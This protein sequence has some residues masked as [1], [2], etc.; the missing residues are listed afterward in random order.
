ML[1]ALMLWNEPNNLSHWNFHLDPGWRVYAAM[2]RQAAQAVRHQAPALTIVA[3][4]ISPID[5]DFVRLLTGE[6]ALESV[7]VLGIHGFPLDWN[8]WRMNEWP[9]K[10]LE[11]AAET[12]KV[13]W[14]TEVGASSFGADE[15]Q[16]FG[17]EA[18]ARLLLDTGGQPERV[19]WYS[20]LDLPP[21]WAA[22]T[23]HRESEGSAYYRHYH[24][25][26]LD[27]QGRPKPAVERFPAGMGVCQW[28][29]FQD[30]RLDL[31]TDWLRRLGVRRL[32][33][34]MSWADWFRP[35]AAAWFDRQMAALAEFDVT[36]TLC[37]TPAHLGIEPHYASPPRDGQEF[38]A[39]AHWV[40]ERYA[41]AA[42][43]AKAAGGGRQ[44]L[45]TPCRLAPAA[46]IG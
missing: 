20:L 6:G 32:R 37:Y 31:A 21:S 4:G 2:V 27:A 38:A 14:A 13:I 1:E 19:Y 46:G 36:L 3:G 23:R 40:A 35:G 12:D 22:T 44:G 30:H 26:L 9:R 25:G 16:V 34:G 10:V 28:F 33:T 39:F 15:V 8:H 24:M 5:P 41:P 7:D 45:Q 43:E 18:T 17:L 11:V 29:H 42:L